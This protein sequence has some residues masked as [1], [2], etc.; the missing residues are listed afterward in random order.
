M[1]KE[2]AKKTRR[3]LRGAALAALRANVRAIESIAVLDEEALDEGARLEIG[4]CIRIL[5]R[6]S[7][8]TP[9]EL[10]GVGKP[11]SPA[12]IQLIKEAF[13][14]VRQR[15]TRRRGPVA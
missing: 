8:L 10:S 2:H 9:D 13:A 6:A 1:D 3:N 15:R 4:R 5:L 12:S 11:L 7:P 14:S